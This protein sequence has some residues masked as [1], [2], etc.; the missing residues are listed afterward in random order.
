MIGIILGI[1]SFLI[2]P[3]GL[4]SIG[5]GLVAFLLMP[6]LSLV[7]PFGIFARFMMRLATFPLKRAA[8]V[9]SEHN[10]AYYKSM[11]FDGLGFETINID[12]ETKVFEDPDDSL[13]YFLGIPFALANEEHGVLFDPRHAAMGKRKQEYDDRG[14]G[15]FLAT[16]DEWQTFDVSLWKPG[17]FEFPKVHELVD[18]SNVKHLIDGGE[19]SEFAER[20]ET[21]YEHSRDPFDD[22]S[23]ATKY[24][25]PIIAFA[26]IFGG[27]WFM[28][29][30]FG[31]PSAT[32]SVSF[33]AL[34]LLF[35]LSSIRKISWGSVIAAIVLIAMPLAII[36]VLFVV[37]GLGTL[38]GILVGFT[39]GFLI[40]PMLTFLG[41]ASSIIGGALSKLYLKLGMLGYRKPVI[42]WTPRKYELVEYRYLDH[43]DDVEWYSLFGSLVGFTFE[44]DESS[45]G[46]E[47]EPHANL[48]AQQVSTDGGTVVDSNLPANY[49]RANEIGKQTDTYGGF[50]PKR[51]KDDHY[52]INTQ[53]ALNRFV[54]SANGEK[55]LRK[56]LEAKETH[57]DSN[58]GLDES[59][60]FKTTAVSGLLGAVLGLGIFVL[61]ALL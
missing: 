35:S 42:K 21:L 7:T 28:A 44:P 14:E 46:P 55:S 5:I 33:G 17:V 41:Q 18:L 24:L 20:V 52:Y 57:G 26:A 48:E 11:T 23:S 9:I 29:S 38:L 12:G 34:F 6:V 59:M 56:L 1:L 27:I 25:Y 4:M 10:D 2:S 3:F 54:G 47:V 45:W 37:I 13:H 60:V 43:T 49:V 58:S 36:Y 39:I 53:I 15:E 40:F 31:A 16:E 32:D 22:G 19:R 8:I 50:V 51:L 30:Q 61:P